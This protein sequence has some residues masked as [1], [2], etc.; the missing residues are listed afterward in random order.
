MFLFL[1]DEVSI[2]DISQ[3]DQE[4]ENRYDPGDDLDL[5]EEED[6][7]VLESEIEKMRMF[8]KHQEDVQLTIPKTKSKHKT[9]Y[10]FI[11]ESKDA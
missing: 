6:F 10:L 5:S 2:Q 8:L 7:D 1:A 11:C 4:I 9:Y 3:L